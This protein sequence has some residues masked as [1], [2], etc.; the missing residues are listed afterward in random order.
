MKRKLAPI[1]GLVGGVGSGKSAVA[2]WLSEHH[3]GHLI[4]ADLVGHQVL[5]QDDVKQGLRRAFGDSIFRDGEIDRRQLA[6]VVFGDEPEQAAARTKLEQIVHPVMGQVIRDRMTASRLD[7]D[8]RLIVFD[9]AILLESGW[10]DTCD[11]VAFVDVPC[12]QRLR[13]IADSRGWTDQELSRREASQWPLNRKREAS[14]VVI[15]NSGTVEQ[16]GL[17]LEDYLI[18]QGWLAPCQQKTSHAPDDT[19]KE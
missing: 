13:R 5:F 6:A 14:D 3:Q 1:I 9:A 12:D 4:D 16:A 2:R 15:D 18:N 19:P 11:V 17:Q 7:E 10:R 8:M